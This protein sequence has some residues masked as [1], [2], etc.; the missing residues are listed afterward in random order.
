M[1][2]STEAAIRAALETHLVG[3]T[4]AGTGS[5]GDIGA[6]AT[7][8]VRAAG[9][10]L[11]DGFGVGDTVRPSGFADQTLARV[12][13]VSDAVLVVDRDVTPESAGAAVVL[14]V[15]LPA[16]RRFEGQPFARPKDQPWLRAALRPQASPLVAFGSGGV[17]RYQGA[18]LVELAEPVDAGRG[19]AR[20]ERLAGAL[21]RQFRPGSRIGDL[22][23]RVGEATRG[24][25]Q[26]Q[27]DF[28][29]LPLSI[30]WAC[31]AAA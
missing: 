18:F 9:S 29:V 14:D 13:A 3:T 6:T 19:L 22:G 16:R 30:D 7:G 8:Y 21:R 12:L 15:V 28:L 26:E 2:L 20:A 25:L 31:D 17:I 5:R 23:I 4:I 1:S 24:T 11:A 27:A 10:F